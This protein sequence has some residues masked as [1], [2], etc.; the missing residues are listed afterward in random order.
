MLVAFN[1]NIVPML[2]WLKTPTTEMTMGYPTMTIF[3]ITTF[4]SVFESLV[5]TIIN[6]TFAVKEHQ[7][8]S[9][10]HMEQFEFGFAIAFTFINGLV[11][12]FET[13][14]LNFVKDDVMVRASILE[15]STFENPFHRDIEAKLKIDSK[16]DEHAHGEHRGFEETIHLLEEENRQLKVRLENDKKEMNSRVNEMEEHLLSA[17][18][19]NNDELFQ[20]IK[21]LERLIGNQHR[22]DIQKDHNENEL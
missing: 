17:M 14:F 15:L 12:V 4:L 16:R 21:E 19:S 22:V 9:Q 3:Y 10:S 7:V 1:P 13:L 11:A 8:F 18:K 5:L 6:A 2:P 20:R